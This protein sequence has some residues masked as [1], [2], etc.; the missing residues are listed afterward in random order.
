MQMTDMVILAISRW[1]SI[2]CIHIFLFNSAR[3]CLETKT[4]LKMVPIGFSNESG[5][6]DHSSPLP[7]RQNQILSSH[8]KLLL[9][10]HGSEHDQELSQQN[11][12]TVASAF[13]KGR[14]RD[15]ADFLKDEMQPL[16]DALLAFQMSCLK[17]F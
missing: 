6:T 10:S 4:A 13:S 7:L 5:H 15:M 3:I 14:Q 8:R 11:D 1:N 12:R 17:M 9:E 16:F 2:K